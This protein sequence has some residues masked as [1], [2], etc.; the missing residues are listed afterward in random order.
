MSDFFG[1]LMRS[2]GFG[3]APLRPQPPKAA[4]DDPFEHV[5]ETEAPS[6]ADGHP[7]HALDAAHSREAQTSSL[8]VRPAAAA[9]ADPPHATA[10]T[11]ATAAAARDADSTRPRSES[12]QTSAALSATAAAAPAP[13]RATAA[14]LHPVVQAA[15][16]WVAADP[17]LRP[18]SA[19]TAPPPVA[20]PPARPGQTVETP[21]ASRRLPAP[22]PAP[23]RTERVDA[24]PVLAAQAAQP[25]AAWPRPAAASRETPSVRIEP[26]ARAASAAPKADAQSAPEVH[27]G[28]IHLTVDA[29]RP[30]Q[31]PAPPPARPASP[32]RSAPARSAYLRSRAPRV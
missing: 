8:D 32:S 26:S 6:S 18:S 27:I 7:T 23:A 19:H 12:P 10:A 9:Q 2:A 24:T 14:A 11:A 28:S 30:A 31:P 3:A 17:A 13:L 20:E 29:P 4:D 16:R 1:A 5:V 15:L 22:M 25:R 21:A